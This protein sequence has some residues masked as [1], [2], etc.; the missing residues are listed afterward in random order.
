[1][2]FFENLFKRAVQNRVEDKLDATKTNALAL[3]DDPSSFMKKMAEDRIRQSVIGAGL[4]TDEEYEA[5]LKEQLLKGNKEK[6][7]QMTRIAPA[8]VPYSTPS[9]VGQ[10]PNYLNFSQHSLRGL[11]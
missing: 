2:A 9:F 11:Y 3:L 1:M 10:T 4:M 6:A 5:F 8:R 7:M